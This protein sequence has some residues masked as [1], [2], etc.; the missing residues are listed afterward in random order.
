MPTG[1]TDE[2]NYDLKFLNTMNYNHEKVYDEILENE[3]LINEEVIQTMNSYEKLRELIEK[4]ILYGHGR[5][6]KMRPI[7]IVNFR[8]LVDNNVDVD[9]F[10]RLND[11]IMSYIIANAML[12]GQIEQ[13]Q[14]IIDLR[15]VA[16]TEI[17]I[18]HLVGVSK[19]GTTFYKQRSTATLG[20][21]VSWIIRAAVKFLY[22]FFDE[23]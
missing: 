17:P 2:H 15:G 3:R 10:F 13:W 21:G 1:F 4:G 19:R 14:L 9:E 11:F 18:S 6:R 23:F 8:R 20:I 16:L 12:P 22:N 5:D 7:V